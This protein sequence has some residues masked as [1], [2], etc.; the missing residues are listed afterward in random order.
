MIVAK[1]ASFMLDDAK[2]HLAYIKAHPEKYPGVGF[3]VDQYPPFRWHPHLNRACILTGAR[4]TAHTDGNRLLALWILEPNGWAI[5]GVKQSATACYQ[6]QGDVVILHQGRKHEV[7]WDRT[8]PRPTQPWIYLAIDFN[9]QQPSRW[10]QPGGYSSEEA[11]SE[12]LWAIRSITTLESYRW[13]EP[14]KR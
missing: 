14:A 11:L 7:R 1:Q 6:E 10:H 4:E 9:Q 3:S 8:Q 5:K 13:L 12:A 2:R